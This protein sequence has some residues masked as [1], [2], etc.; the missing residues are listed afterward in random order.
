MPTQPAANNSAG[1]ATDPPRLPQKRRGFDAAFKREV[2]AF[3]AASA[4]PNITQTAQH[5][6]VQQSG[7]SRWIQNAEAIF[8]A[9]ATRIKIGKS[10]TQPILPAPPAA[11][12]ALV[13]DTMPPATPMPPTALPTPPNLPPP[14]PRITSVLPV[15]P[16]VPTPP[17]PTQHNTPVPPVTLMAP[18]ILP[19]HPA[20]PAVPP[21][22]PPTLITTIPIQPAPLP[23]PL[24]PQAPPPPVQLPPEDPSPPIIFP[25]L[26]APSPSTAAWRKGEEKVE[27]AI[28]DPEWAASFWSGTP[29]ELPNTERLFINLVHS[30]LASEWGTKKPP[31]G[32]RPRDKKTKAPPEVI[33][34]LEQKHMELRILQKQAIRSNAPKGLLRSIDKRIWKTRQ[35]LRVFKKREEDMA[36]ASEMD[37]NKEALNKTPWKLAQAILTGQ[38][39]GKPPE[40]D[41]DTL[42]AH[43]ESTLTDPCPEAVYTTLPSLPGRPVAFDIRCPF[44]DPSPPHIS[45]TG[46]T[47]LLKMKKMQAAPG[48]DGIP[49]S[50]YK[51]MKCLHPLIAHMLNQGL[52]E[53]ATLPQNWTSAATIFLYKKGPPTD[54]SN[55]RP[56]CLGS[57]LGKL[58]TSTLQQS[59]NAHMDDWKAWSPHQ[60]GFRTKVAGCIEQQVMLDRLTKRAGG[61]TLVSTDLSN[62][63]GTVKHSHIVYALWRYHFPSWIITKV[64]HLYRQL[65]WVLP[66]STTPVRQRIGVFQGDPL[67]PTLFNVALNVILELLD[68]TLCADNHG[69]SAF[70]AKNWADSGLRTPLPKPVTHLTFADDVLLVGKSPAH[71]QELINIF[72]RGLDWSLTLRTRASK[73]G[74]IEY[75][76]QEGGV[77]QTGSSTKAFISTRTPHLSLQGVVI[78]PITTDPNTWRLLGQQIPLAKPHNPQAAQNFTTQHIATLLQRIDKAPLSDT[79]KLRVYQLAFAAYARWHLQV[80]AATPKWVTTTLYPMVVRTLKKW[81]AAGPS[82]NT[83]RLFLPPAQNGLGLS[84]PRLLWRASK[85]QRALLISTSKDPSIRAIGLLHKMDRGVKWNPFRTLRTLSESLQQASPPIKVSSKSLTKLMTAEHNAELLDELR[86]LPCQGVLERSPAPTPKALWL[87]HFH[88]LPL[89]VVQF[90]MKALSN[91]LVTGEN[92]Q[93]WFPGTR[94]AAHC[95]RCP[96]EFQTLTHVLAQ[97]CIQLNIGSHDPRNRITWRHNEVLRTIVNHIKKNSPQWAIYGDLKGLSRLPSHYLSTTSTQLPDLVLVSAKAIVIGELTAPMEHNMACQHTIKTDKYY[98]LC[99]NIAQANPDMTVDLQCFEVGARGGV[100]STLK[101]FFQ[102][103]RMPN[104]AV[105]SAMD[106]ASRRAVECSARIFKYR[107]THDWPVSLPT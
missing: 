21:T 20:A 74:T 71:A 69:V 25:R 100:T 10:S 2:L 36:L 31:G 35:A 101:E 8:Q 50:V 39:E 3:H 14:A 45:A 93:I 82:F 4:K 86:A 22:T 91:T 54:P 81:A 38:Q 65:Q 17:S 41:P 6:D 19:T 88:D 76:R 18:D 40:C 48:L 94:S 51:R 11:P 37:R 64:Q 87:S 104:K 83:G 52:H 29:Q 107:D 98:G 34:E 1:S 9:P 85:V 46:L 15:T 92:R 13:T 102:I 24:I 43:W 28:T 95:G 68:D 63:F 53:K 61:L 59:V 33:I 96:A 90:G 56:I 55:F 5:F 97:C 26:K 84:D 57:S 73:F 62:A 66:G 89:K 44:P 16:R 70:T 23:R 67:S 12:P 79:S 72:Q 47:K 49:V 42:R 32:K 105:K 99:Q 80:N 30:V 7:V 58:F 78:P 75:F 106:A 77:S 27:L 60:K 103:C